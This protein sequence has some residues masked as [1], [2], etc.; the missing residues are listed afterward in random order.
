MISVER[1]IEYTKLETDPNREKKALRADWPNRGCIQFKDLKL[2]YKLNDPYV[3]KGV[4]ISIAAQEKIGIV[5]RT[6]A[7]K[8]SMISALFQLYNLEGSII[9]DDVDITEMPLDEVRSKVSIIP[10][11][12]VL[13]SGKIWIIN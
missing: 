10:Q 13:F 2:R 9:I 4:N 5:G 7:G 11:E 6:G 1:V 8:S 12:P 3:L